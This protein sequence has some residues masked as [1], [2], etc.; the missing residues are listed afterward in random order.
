ML[1]YAPYDALT[2]LA[3]VAGGPLAVLCRYLVSDLPSRI[4]TKRLPLISVGAW[5]TYVSYG[6]AAVAGCA[7]FHAANARGSAGVAVAAVTA[8]MVAVAVNWAIASGLFRKLW[9]GGSFV[10]LAR[11]EFLAV[12]P[13]ELG[14][15]MLAALVLLLIP[16]LGDG[17]LLPLGLTTA[18]PALALPALARSRDVS[19]LDRSAVTR[20]YARALSARLGLTRSQRRTMLAAATLSCRPTD[21]SPTKASATEALPPLR[22]GLLRGPLPPAPIDISSDPAMAWKAWHV[23]RQASERWDGP[24]GLDG[25]MRGRLLPVE[26]RLLAVAVEWAQLTAA[27]G[28]RLTQREAALAL[29]SEAGTR[30][31][32]HIVE[33][34]GEIVTVEEQFASLE[35]FQP[36]LDLLPLP[37]V[38]RRELLPWALHAYSPAA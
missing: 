19:T 12:L 37:R 27:G 23:V 24:D 5:A 26:A 36:R 18:L 34:A 22:S 16:V 20:H 31:D 2:T 33:A 13:M 14:Q 29:A 4:V 38:V 17:I 28:P 8:G 21:A 25:Q 9:S 32:P 15:Q 11:E 30:F 6:Y 35:T 1:Y 3:L 7:V 10:A